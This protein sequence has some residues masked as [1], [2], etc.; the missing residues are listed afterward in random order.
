MNYPSERVGLAAG[1]AAFLLA[2]SS[3]LAQYG[4]PES[5]PGPS[6][7]YQPGNQIGQPGQYQPEQYQ[8]SP[9]RQQIQGQVLR[10][11]RINVASTN[12]AI[13][14]ALVE[15]T[16]GRRV[17]VDL[18]PTRN[19]RDQDVE[20]RTGD[21]IVAR[22]WFSRVA[23]VP[24]LLANRV[25]ANGQT[26]AIR[27]EELPS[28]Q[29]LEHEEDLLE[30]YARYQGQGTG[31]GEF[32]GRQQAYPY[33]QSRSPNEGY[34]GEE[35]AGPA[36]HFRGRIVRTSRVLLPGMR[37]DILF[38]LIRTNQGR[39]VSL[40]LGPV[41]DFENVAVNRGDEI[42]V[43]GPVHEIHGQPIVLAREFRI[44]GQTVPIARRAREETI[45]ASQHITGH[46]VRTRRLRIPGISEPLL[47]ALV[48]TNQGRSIIAELGSEPRL[49]G[50]TLNPG[51]EIDVRGRAF[52]VDN[53]RILLAERIRAN[54]QIVTVEEQP[55]QRAAAPGQR[56]RLIRVI[57]ED[58][59]FEPNRI[60]AQPGELLN[61]ELTN[62]SADLPHSIVFDLPDEEV[63]PQRPLQP[64]DSHIVTVRVPE[65]PGRYVFYCP[66]DDH[67]QMGMKGY[68]V[69]TTPAY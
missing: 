37:E 66:V 15:T 25:Q 27:R 68:L 2:G 18:G 57:A 69:V 30:T 34:G 29:R 16:K 67:A 28:Q 53:Y 22:G 5:V 7:Q 31:Y 35:Q 6:E 42:D 33:S 8:L 64:G 10:T 56:R 54:G 46:I 39:P 40:Y 21:E 55:R 9:Q 12:T 26:V 63:G 61:I 38:A 24:V 41:P 32:Q 47:I 43:R 20:I 48:R 13:L 52:R 17:I 51:D 45:A 65:E 50:L 60:T 1:I 44:H 49:E 62:S 14:A 3:C 11:R 36:E 4:Q 23:N 58:F 59:R 19:L